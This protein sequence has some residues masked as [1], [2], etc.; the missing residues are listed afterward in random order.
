MA[1]VSN[2]NL[3]KKKRFY[4]PNEDESE[5]NGM[6]DGGDTHDGPFRNLIDW[7]DGETSP[8]SLMPVGWEDNARI[9]AVPKRRG[10]LLQ[11]SSVCSG[12]GGAA[13]ATASAIPTSSQG[14]MAVD[15]FEDAPFLVLDRDVDME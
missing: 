5:E 14:V 2:I 9:L 12:G 15:D 13:A 7:I 1:A 3:N 11:R 6:D 4:D 10:N 8:R